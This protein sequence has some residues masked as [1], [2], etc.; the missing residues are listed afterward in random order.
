[1]KRLFREH[2]DHEAADARANPH[3]PQEA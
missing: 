2:K 3:A 1:V